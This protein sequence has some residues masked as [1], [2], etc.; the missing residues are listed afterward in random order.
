MKKFE[1]KTVV[2]TGGARGIGKAAADL[3]QEEGANVC[4]WDFTESDGSNHFFCKVDVSPMAQC[5]EAAK[6]CV[7][8]FGS[9]HVLVNNAGITRDALFAK[10]TEEQWNKVIDVNLNGVFNATKAVVD[11][12]NKSI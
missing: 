12:K 3:F 5:S 4:V 11:I 8:K 2:I 6:A 10:M 7:E 9:I 1:N